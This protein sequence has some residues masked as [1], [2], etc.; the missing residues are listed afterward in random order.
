MKCP[1]YLAGTCKKDCS[2][3]PYCNNSGSYI[4]EDSFGNVHKCRALDGLASKL[5]TIKHEEKRW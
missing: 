2:G 3:K 4:F 5:K 1:H